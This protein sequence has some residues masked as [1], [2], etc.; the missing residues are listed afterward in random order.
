EVRLPGAA[1]VHVHRDRHGR[2]GLRG[3]HRQQR[4]HQAEPRFESARA[5][6]VRTPSR[7]DTSRDASRIHVAVARN[8]AQSRSRDGRPR[9]RRRRRVLSDRHYRVGDQTLTVAFDPATGLPARV[10]TLDYDNI[11][12]DVAYDL[13][14]SDWQ[15]VDG[16]KVAMTRKYEL[17]E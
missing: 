14:L 4:A 3:R 10:R 16:V 12:G 11:W 5:H 17:N 8:A 13:L 15:T 6:D 7:R 9:C 1:H 2:V